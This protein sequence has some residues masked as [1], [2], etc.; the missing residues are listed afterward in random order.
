MKI[1]IIGLFLFSC[2]PRVAIKKGYDITKIR[3]IYITHFIPF[4]HQTSSASMVMDEFTRQLMKSGFNIV[5]DPAKAQ[6]VL[7]GTVT[8][9]Y[10]SKKFFI[11]TPDTE[12]AK[13]TTVIVQHPPVEISGENVYSRGTVFGFGGKAEILVSN[14]TLGV[15]A[16]L[17]D[18]K[19]EE[20]VWANSYL[21]EGLDIQC[22]TEAVVRYLVK[23]ILKAK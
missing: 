21:Y 5:T 12:E 1:L 18:P 2:A 3:N 9:F 22:V 20:V 19:T 17:V 10:P 23:S 16:K 13:E 7:Y 8:Q 14:S 11:Y 6:L 15:S 4:R